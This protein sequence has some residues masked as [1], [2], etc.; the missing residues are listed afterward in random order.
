MGRDGASWREAS[1]PPS[2]LRAAT[3]P[4]RG[5]TIS[6]LPT[7]KP[8]SP[9]RPPYDEGVELIAIG[10]AEIARVKS[11]APP[12]RRACEGAPL[13]PPHGIEALHLFSVI[14]MSGPPHPLPPP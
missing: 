5:G 10:I 12:S 8:P 7:P 6:P 3:S 2:A 13:P 14:L 4:F 11:L 9:A 1:T